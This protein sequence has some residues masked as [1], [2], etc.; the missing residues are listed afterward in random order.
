M[1]PRVARWIFG[2]SLAVRRALH[3][4]TGRPWWVRLDAHVLMGAFPFAADVPALAAS[5]VRGVVNL[6]A[7]RR[8]P[9]S[10][11]RAHGLEELH[12]PVVD[13]AEPSEEVVAAALDFLRAHAARDE[14][15]YLH[16]KAGRGR[17]ATIALCWLVE[18]ER[19]SPDEAMRKLRAASPSVIAGLERRQ[20]VQRRWRQLRA[21]GIG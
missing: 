15:V 2:P 21:D 20:V 9:R 16:C 19:I 12:L 6:C 1:H 10:R 17:S 13:F 18:R 7:E 4:L 8:G 14:R 3:G 11:Y 5:G